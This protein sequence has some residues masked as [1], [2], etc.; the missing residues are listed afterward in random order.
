V[1]AKYKLTLNE[2]RLILILIAQIKPEDQEFKEY[3]IK[4]SDLQTLFEITD[5]GYYSKIKKVTENLLSKPLSIP[6]QKGR[7]LC[8]WI[9]SAEY[10]D[11]EGYVKLCFDPKLKPYLLQLKSYF[12]AYGLDNLIR[13]KSVYSIRLYE[14]LLKEYRYYG[15]K[16]FSFAFSVKELKTM[17]GIEESEYP[18]FNNFKVKVLEVAEKE[19]KAKSNLYFEYKTIKTVRAITDIE[20]FVINKEKKEE[21]TQKQL[22]QKENSKETVD[23]NHSPVEE[24][25]TDEIIKRLIALGFQDYKK[26]RSEHSDEVLL[27]AFADLD[28]EIE[29]RKKKKKES[30]K[31]VG[32][33]V[34]KRLP[35]AG[36]P[37]QRSL[38]HNKYLEEQD[39]KKQ[40]EEIKHQEQLKA[41]QER[42]R[43]ER[44]IKE[45]DERINAKIEDLKLNSPE[46]WEEI[47]KEVRHKVS[48]EVKPPKQEKEEKE[49][50]KSIISEL[51]EKDR[52]ILELD[53]VEKAKTSLIG[54][55]LN[56]DSKNFNSVL[57]SV[58]ASTFEAIVKEKYLS[59]I[60]NQLKE[61]S[62]YKTYEKKFIMESNE[63]R[64]RIII[65]KLKDDI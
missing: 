7:L 59:E 41:K 50:I 63:I 36:Q 14:I 27:N 62:Y 58:K 52:K 49:I 42:E 30:L 25:E 10:L 24:Q 19:L 6:T 43:Q 60:E 55:G 8:N 39:K 57:K 45:L 47:E 2:H 16:R 33:W 46:E 35:I 23:I 53:A 5:N 11:D 18:F 32:A 3:F 22:A 29:D 13:L 37:F 56:E 4:I 9:S 65:N 31:N 34:R 40:Q 17:L 48:S 51:T 21:K 20:F 38:H 15:K 44:L 64:R 12:T 28:F 26:I 1:E 54:L 61:T